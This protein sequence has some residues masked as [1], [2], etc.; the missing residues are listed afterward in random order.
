MDTPAYLLPGIKKWSLGF[1]AVARLYTSVIPKNP[2]KRADKESWA[3][4]L[5]PTTLLLC[6]D[7][8][9]QCSEQRRHG[10]RCTRGGWGPGGWPGGLYRYPGPPSHIPIFSHILSLRPYLWP[11]EGNS[12]VFYE[13][14]QI[15]YKNGPRID[16]ELTQNRPI[17]RP[18]QTGP[19]MA[20]DPSYPD[21]R[22]SMVYNGRYLTFY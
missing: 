14:S 7:W 22:Y 17:S 21:L 19:E 20:S 6:H 2:E 13:V 16:P 4:D 1:P 11:N 18:P 3:T 5:S 10:G 12:Q 8:V 9:R 15:G